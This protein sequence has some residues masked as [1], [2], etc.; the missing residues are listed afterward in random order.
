[1]LTTLPPSRDDFLEMWEPEPPGTLCPSSGIAFT[2]YCVIL[3]LNYSSVVL[4]SNAIIRFFFK[5]F[6]NLL[7]PGPR[8]ATMTKIWFR[9]STT[10]SVLLIGLLCFSFIKFYALFAKLRKA[11]IN[12]IVSVCV[13]A[14]NNSA[15]TRRIFMKFLYFCNFPKYVE[16]IQVPL[17]SDNNNRYFTWRPIYIIDH[18]SLS[19]Y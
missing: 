15:P 12:L 14:W 19:Y 3:L 2:F 7:M 13:F 9:S 4:S 6:V 8:K 16:Q 1:M 11:I 18:I 17:K 5:A 10:V